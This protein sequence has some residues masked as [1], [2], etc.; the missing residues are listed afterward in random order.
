MSH[1][2]VDKARDVRYSVNKDR[3]VR[4]SVNKDRDVGYSVNKDRDV[5][6][7]VNKDRDVRYS[8]DY[9]IKTGT[10]CVPVCKCNLQREVTGEKWQK[11]NG[12][13]TSV[14]ELTKVEKS[15]RKQMEH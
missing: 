12:A 4:Y 15:E 3:D 10:S 1:T 8:A 6:Y 14:M 13:L 2:S 5:G 7:S 9:L 11:T